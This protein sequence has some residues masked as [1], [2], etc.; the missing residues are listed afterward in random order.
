MA[1]VDQS[2]CVQ[3]TP[4]PFINLG[5]SYTDMF[6][7]GKKHPTVGKIFVPLYMPF[8]KAIKINTL[9]NWTSW[10]I[11]WGYFNLS[12]LHACQ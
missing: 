10:S 8:L 6:T 4:V 11:I 7:L 1:D 5:T 12:F 2:K 3:K 9:F